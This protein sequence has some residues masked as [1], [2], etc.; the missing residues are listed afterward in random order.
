MPADVDVFGAAADVADVGAEA[1]EVVDGAVDGG[2][3]AGDGAGGEDDGVAGFDG[4]VA[5]VAD[6]HAGEGGH[7]FALG[8]GADE[9]DV[10][11]ADGGVV[12]DVADEA[13]GGFD[14]GE[15]AG[16]AEVVFHGSAGDEDGAAGGV[17]AI[18]DL[19]EAGDLGGEG[20]DDD[21]PGGGE[22]DLFERFADD[23]FGEGVVGV[24]GVGGV[25]AEEADAFAAVEGDAAEVGGF[26]HDGG[27]VDLE[28]AGVDDGAGGRMEGDAVGVRDGVG[29]IEEFGLDGSEVEFGV[30]VDDDAFDCF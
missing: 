15:I 27:V 10:F 1:E 5:V 16:H 17:G 30:F 13:G 12:F 18:D 4:D 11:V 26:A 23:E 24:V 6:G 21:A 29:D 19:L 25:T 20:G 2:F 7:G 28:V 14:V 22:H 9:G 8:A 3:V